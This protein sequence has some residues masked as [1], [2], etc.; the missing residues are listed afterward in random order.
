MKRYPQLPEADFER[1]KAI[2]LP[3]CLPEAA[4]LIRKLAREVLGQVA[5]QLSR[6]SCRVAGLSKT[7]RPAT[8]AGERTHEHAERPTCSG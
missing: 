7:Q 5:D 6:K 8:T 2:V 4:Y 3:G 1:L